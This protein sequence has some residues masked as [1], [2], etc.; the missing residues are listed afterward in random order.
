MKFYLNSVTD[1]KKRK[2]THTIG[3]AKLF[4]LFSFVYISPHIFVPLRTNLKPECSA[5]LTFYLVII[6]FNDLANEQ[7]SDSHHNIREQARNFKNEKEKS[8]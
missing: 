1:N 6:E 2:K 4:L 5:R 7:N 8:K 3:L